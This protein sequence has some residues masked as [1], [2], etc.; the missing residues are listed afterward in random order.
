[1]IIE[2]LQARRHF[3]KL[4]S[5][6]SK[7]RRR[8]FEDT[9]DLRR[10]E[11]G[12]TR[13]GSKKAVETGLGEAESVKRRGVVV[14]ATRI[15]RRIKRCPRLFFRQGTV[16]IAQRGGAKSQFR[17]IQFCAASRDEFAFSHALSARTPRPRRFPLV[18]DDRRPPRRETG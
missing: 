5:T 18:V 6:C 4:F 3:E 16:H 13:L 10:D 11:I 2:A 14:A 7:L 15:P 12:L 1:G 8:Q 9:T 17:K